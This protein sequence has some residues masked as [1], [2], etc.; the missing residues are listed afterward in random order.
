[1]CIRD[2]EK[3]RNIT[4]SQS[5]V[6]YIIDLFSLEAVAND[7]AACEVYRR[8]DG[9]ISATANAILTD[10]LKTKKNIILDTTANKFNVEGRGK[11]P[12]RLIGEIATRGVS[13]KSKSSAGYLFF[14]TYDGFNFR[15]IDN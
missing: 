4:S 2:R 8:F 12:F 15:S 13:A 9:E 11:K 6:T 7:L 10:A 3:V 14:E 1:M 5:G